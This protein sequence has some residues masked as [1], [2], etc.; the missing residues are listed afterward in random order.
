MA[1]LAMQDQLQ[2]RLKKN[3]AEKLAGPIET[4]IEADRTDCASL[5][6]VPKLSRRVPAILAFFGVQPKKVPLF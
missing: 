2:K 4:P 1:I 3:R 5:V 6:L